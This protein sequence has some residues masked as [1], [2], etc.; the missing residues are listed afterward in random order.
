[1]SLAGAYAE[2]YWAY[3]KMDVPTCSIRFAATRALRYHA[4]SIALGSVMVGAFS[5]VRIKLLKVREQLK[6]TKATHCCVLCLENYLKYIIKKSFMMIAV[7]GLPYLSSCQQ[8]SLLIKRYANFV[9]VPDNMML[10]LVLMFV[11]MVATT[12]GLAAYLFY[13]TDFVD[14]SHTTPYM[15]VC[16]W[17]PIVFVIIVA[18]VIAQI[19]FDVYSV[20]VDTMFMC[21]LNDLDIHDGTAVKPYFMTIGLMKV[22]IKHEKGEDYRDAAMRVVKTPDPRAESTLGDTTV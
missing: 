8:S 4:G 5:S 9:I 10:F 6:D 7:H 19:F 2:Y 20:A 11:S 21:L 1:M 13:I 16:P 17:V 3:D 14:K 18:I 22:F 12:A 15:M